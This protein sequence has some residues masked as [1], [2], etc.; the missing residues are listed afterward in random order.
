MKLSIQARGLFLYICSLE[1]NAGKVLGHLLRLRVRGSVLCSIESWD[2][3]WERVLNQV[4]VVQKVD[5][6]I[7]RI[8]LYPLDSVI[9]FPNIY[10]L[11]GD[12][13]DG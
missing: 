1:W 6:A 12:L 8:N 9:G 13:S 7:H 2:C 10:P 5:N 11:D 4:P 3:F